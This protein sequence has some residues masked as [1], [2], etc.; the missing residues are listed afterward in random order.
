MVKNRMGFWAGKK[1]LVTGGAGFV[2]SHVVDKLKQK[3]CNEIYVP[4]S[5]HYNLVE[6][7]DVCRLFTDTD[8]DIVIH[9]AGKVGGIMANIAAPA[10]FYYKNLMMGTLTMEYARRAGVEKF[11]ALIPGCSY[12][13]DCEI[14]FKERYYWDGFPEPTSAPYAIAKKVLHIQS[15]AYREQYGFNSIIL[16]P[17]NLYGPR[18]NFNPETSHV[19]PALIRKFLEA[20]EKGR[21]EVTVWGTGKPTRS[22]FYIEDCAEAMLV[23]TEKYNKSE[24]LNLDMGKETSILELAE[25]IKELTEFEGKIIW[26][27]SK[28]DG[29]PRRCFDV[30]RAK[31]EIGFVARTNLRRGLEKTIEW[32]QK[33]RHLY[34]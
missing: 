28:P 27:R 33:N 1:V 11:T 29:Q 8:P 12:P 10:E 22:F 15:M 7:K 26:D 19:I 34:E 23:A 18:D 31:E 21:N 13:R 3:N 9:L 4:R 6:E 5:K 16:I 25:M 30:S 2:G 32:Y 17:G 14:P 20:K 24:P